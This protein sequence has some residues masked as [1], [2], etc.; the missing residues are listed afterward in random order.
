[1]A[2]MVTSGNMV[3]LFIGWEG[4][5]LASFLLINFWYSRPEAN[6]SALK[7]IIMNKFG[8][9]FFYMFMVLSYSFYKTFDFYLLFSLVCVDPVSADLIFLNISKVDILAMSL[10]IAAVGKSA[11]LGLHS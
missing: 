9:M 4:I 5:G 1:M 7:A 2:L 3:Q 8:D 6:R 10:V 11:Q